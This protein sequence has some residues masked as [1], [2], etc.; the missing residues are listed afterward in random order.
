MIVLPR[1]CYVC[2]LL[3]SICNSAI[4]RL[5]YRVSYVVRMM[6]LWCCHVVF[7]MLLCCRRGRYDV[8]MELLLYWS[9]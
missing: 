2:V 3:L 7:A 1:C 5:F 4:A 9:M 8:V 6:L